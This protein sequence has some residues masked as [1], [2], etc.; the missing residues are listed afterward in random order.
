MY[1][2]RMDPATGALANRRVFFRLAPGSRS[3]DGMTVDDEA[4]CGRRCGERQRSAAT[5]RTES[6][7]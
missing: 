4:G 3:P 7:C 2:H 5:R 1:A 6:S